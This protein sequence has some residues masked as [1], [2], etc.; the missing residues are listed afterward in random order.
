MDDLHEESSE[1]SRLLQAIG[2]SGI[3]LLDKNTTFQLHVDL[4]LVVEG[5]NDIDLGSLV[6]RLAP[7]ALRLSPIRIESES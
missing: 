4:K 3:G 2:L 5:A 1:K 6:A 7:V